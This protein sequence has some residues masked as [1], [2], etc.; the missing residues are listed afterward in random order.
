MAANGVLG[1]LEGVILLAGLIVYYGVA[2]R[3]A[4]A[5]G[6]KKLT[7]ATSEDGH[8]PMESLYGLMVRLV[9]SLVLLLVGSRLLIWGGVGLARTMG[10]SEL[11][12]GL[13][14]VALGTSLPELATT[15]TGIIK[16]QD[17]I[18]VGNVVGSNIFNTLA[19]LGTISILSPLPIASENS[20]RDFPMTLLASLVLWPISWSRRQGRGRVNRFEGAIL[21]GLYGGYLYLLAG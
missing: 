13:T 4:G 3:S 10:V 17:S 12:I 6:N 8:R 5:R 20:S 2:L 21:L 18:A 16:K 9:A 14:L 1:R 15:L 7:G 19:I 11:V